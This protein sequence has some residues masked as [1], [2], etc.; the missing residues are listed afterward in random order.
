MDQGETVRVGLAT[1]SKD[2]KDLKQDLRHQ[3]STFKDDLKREMREEIMNLQQETERGS[4]RKITS[5]NN[6]R[7]ASQKL[8]H[9]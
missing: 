8:R 6:R 7:L 1:I 5:Y 2:N 9:T 3:L 4:Q